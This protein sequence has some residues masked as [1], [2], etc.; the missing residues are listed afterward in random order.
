MMMT[1]GL[2]VFALPTAAYQQLARTTAWRHAEQARV[3]ARPAYQYAGP[4]SD[5]LTLTGTLF[6]EF[7][8]GRVSLD[9]LRTMADTGKGWPLI[10]GTGRLYGNWAITAINETDSEHLRDGAPQKIDFTVELVRVDD[11]NL[12]LLATGINAALS[13]ATGLLAGPLNSLRDRLGL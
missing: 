1:L 10:E 3:G 2:F 5:T 4:G 12:D 7:T 8:G 6:P 9:L 13:G 11:R